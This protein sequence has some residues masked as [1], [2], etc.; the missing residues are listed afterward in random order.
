MGNQENLSFIFSIGKKLNLQNK[1]ILRI[2]NNFKGLKYRQEIIYKNN[3]LLIMNDSKSTSFSSSLNILQSY[4]NIF[5]IVG[6]KFKKGDKFNLKDKYYKNINAYIY[7]KNKN[8]FINSFKNKIK[9]KLFKNIREVLLE[10][11]KDFKKINNVTQNVIFSP[12]AASFD[13]FNNFEDRGKYF[14]FLIKK[15]NFIKKINEK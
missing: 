11:I 13:Q 1:K 9:F 15:L 5:W 12:S 10:V 7:G 4:K 8:L 6:G 14:N 2:V 3:H